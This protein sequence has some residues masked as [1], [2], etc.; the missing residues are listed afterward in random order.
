MCEWTSGCTTES[1]QVVL[2][3]QCK[4]SQH[5]PGVTS[6]ALCECERMHRNLFLQTNRI[7]YKNE[8]WFLPDWFSIRLNDAIELLT[9]FLLLVPHTRTV[10]PS[11]VL[12]FAPVCI[13]TNSTIYTHIDR[14]ENGKKEHKSW[15]TG[16]N[17]L[18]LHVSFCLGWLSA[19]AC[20]VEKG[21]K[22]TPCTRW[23]FPFSATRY[24]VISYRHRSISRFRSKTAN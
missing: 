24:M 21:V 12:T 23:A 10:S 19:K 11:V 20:L 8:C 4:I 22:C 1:N 13:N 6:I 17:E 16:L 9:T 3:C 7:S 14:D 5:T 2:L 15:T 18:Q